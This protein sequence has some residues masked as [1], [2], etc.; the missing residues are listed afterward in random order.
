MAAS[1]DDE[2]RRAAE[3][4]NAADALVVT[5]GAGMGV[6]SGLPDFRG[7]TRVL[8]GVSGTLIRIN[9][10]EED[11]PGGQIGLSLGAAEG[12]QRICACAERLAG[13]SNPRA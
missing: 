9:P 13:R 7:G 12:I 1:T 4:V 10:R 5:A 6:D 3:A 2:V 11:V 8:A